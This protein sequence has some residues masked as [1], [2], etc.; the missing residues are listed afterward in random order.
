MKKTD[1]SFK[2][3]RDQQAN[4]SCKKVRRMVED[5]PEILIKKET[6]RNTKQGRKNSKKKERV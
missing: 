1:M 5:R 2:P 4:K 3:D 6:Q